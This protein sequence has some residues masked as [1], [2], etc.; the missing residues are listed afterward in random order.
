ML[1]IGCACDPTVLWS[2][3]PVPCLQ[4]RK[5]SIWC[6]A[7]LVCSL[8]VALPAAARWL[9]EWRA[10]EWLGSR[11]CTRALL[12]CPRQH[13]DP[14]LL[15]FCPLAPLH[16]PMTF[17]EW[18]RPGA[19]RLGCWGGAGRGGAGSQPVHGSCCSAR[20][21]HVGRAGIIVIDRQ[22]LVPP[23]RPV[24]KPVPA[25]PGA[26]QAWPAARWR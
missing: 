3:V 23:S 17:G 14:D 4:A 12:L 10:G 5:G 20:A 26:T 24:P 21:A 18:W 22:S 6:V 11:R 7:L 9:G 8:S 25:V 15:P 2:A 13:A 1:V 19:L 16:R